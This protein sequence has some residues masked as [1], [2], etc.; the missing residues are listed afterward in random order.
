MQPKSETIGLE[1]DKFD[2]LLSGGQVL[3][4]K[5]RKLSPWAKGG[6]KKYLEFLQEDGESGD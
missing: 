5:E 2:H 4:G 3:L 6:R 1:C